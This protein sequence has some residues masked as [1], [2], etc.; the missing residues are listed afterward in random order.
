M[1]MRIVWKRMV[2]FLVNVDLALQEMDCPVKVCTMLTL[3]HG[4][5][6]KSISPL[7]GS[8]VTKLVLFYLKTPVLFTI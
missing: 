2:H 3:E 6:Y 5:Q 1:L 4:F 7:W 8:V